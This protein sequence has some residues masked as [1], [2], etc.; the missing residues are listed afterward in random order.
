MIV[1]KGKSDALTCGSYRGIV[2]LDHAMKVLENRLKG[3]R[4]RL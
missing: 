1:Y 2:L 3:E 4:E